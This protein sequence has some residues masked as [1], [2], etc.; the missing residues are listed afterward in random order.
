M[1]TVIS[2]ITGQSAA[3][4]IIDTNTPE[5]LV[6]VTNENARYTFTSHGGGLKLVE[7]VGVSTKRERRA[8]RSPTLN[9]QAP[10][11]GVC[12]SRR[13]SRPGKRHLSSNEHRDW[14]SR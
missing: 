2:P 1:T 14:R 9:S 11:P 4:F 3:K 7:L 8:G 10:A 13:R 5:Q 6:T 12:Q